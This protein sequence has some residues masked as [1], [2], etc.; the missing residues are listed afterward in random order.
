M[1]RTMIVVIMLL[2]STFNFTL[3]GIII[4]NIQDVVRSELD[5]LVHLNE[6]SLQAKMNVNKE[7]LILLKYV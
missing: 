3:L 7:S 2:L 6:F 5:S 1:T 4:I